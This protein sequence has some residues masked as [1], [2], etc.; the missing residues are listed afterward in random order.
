MRFGRYQRQAK[1]RREHHVP[2]SRPSARNHYADQGTIWRRFLRFPFDDVWQEAPLG[3]LDELGAAIGRP[4]G[5]GMGPEVFPLWL[6][7]LN[8]GIVLVDLAR[9]PRRRK[10]PALAIDVA[11]AP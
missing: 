8:V 3:K 5:R 4:Q 2:L 9:R 10:A 7:G 11:A 6:G 1:I